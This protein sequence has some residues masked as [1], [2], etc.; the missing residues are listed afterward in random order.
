M[1]GNPYMYI[2]GNLVG[3]LVTPDLDVDAGN[4][5]DTFIRKV[6]PSAQWL[7]RKFWTP[8]SLSVPHRGVVSHFPVISTLI[9]LGYIMAGLNLV[10]VLWWVI[11]RIVGWDDTLHFT[12]LWDWSFFWGLVHVDTMHFLADKFIKG[13]EQFIDE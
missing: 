9:R 2:A 3:I 6:S 11:A 1:D 7:W 12:W 4:I 8:Y 10:K 5:S 13:K